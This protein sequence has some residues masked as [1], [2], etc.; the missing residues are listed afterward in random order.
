MSAPPHPLTPLSNE[1]IEAAVPRLRGR[2][3]L[4]PEDVR[5]SVLIPVYN[6]ESTIRIIVEQVRAVPVRTEII[7]VNDCSSDGSRAVLDRLHE[8]GMIDIL[9]HK[10]KNEG[11]G[12][13]IRTALQ[14][15]TGN[16]VIWIEKIFHSA[17]Q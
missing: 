7:C 11:K 1:V 13:A 4:P 9:V 10:E 12:A 6:E 15:S 3:P 14:R 2:T 16:I 8:A 5:L 17:F